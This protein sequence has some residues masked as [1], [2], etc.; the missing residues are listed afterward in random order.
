M[1][2]SPKTTTELFGHEGA[3]TALLRD[4]S[5]GKL[6]HGWIISGP[7]GIGK[8]TLCY[9]FARHILS[10]C[11]PEQSKGSPS[12]EGDPSTPLRSALDDKI[13]KRIAAG[14]HSDILVVEPIF[15]TKKEE[16]ARDI[17]VGQAREI[18][19]FLS[20][21]PGEGQWRVVI[22]DSVD[23]LNAN[24]ANAILKILEEPPPQAILL[25]ISHNPGRLLPTIRSRCR[26]LKLKALDQQQFTAVMAHIAPEID[27]EEC[28]ALGQLAKLS[29]GLALE[30]HEQGALFLYNQI[31]DLLLSL[32]ALDPVKI[33]AFADAMTAGKT[34]ANWSLFT[35]M[36]LCLFER[37]AIEASGLVLEPLSKN[38][39]KLLQKLAAYHPAHIWAEKWQQVANQFLLAERLHLDYKQIIIVFFH[40][41]SEIEEFKIGNAAA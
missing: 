23:A 36:I 6:A 40:S 16:Y 10:P 35:R 18:A 13:F 1:P 39:E 28:I 4:F 30:F 14:S 17:T 37:I 33:H 25:L 31:L 27:S 19:Q 24:G 41:I 34:H 15:D 5:N 11:H 21:T 20:L 9:H 26:I 2:V 32:P 38:E 3:F 12:I 22:I 29:P 7:Q 8:A